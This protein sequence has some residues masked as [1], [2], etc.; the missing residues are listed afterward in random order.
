MQSSQRL[1]T[2]DE[3]SAPDPPVIEPP[4]ESSYVTRSGRV[5]K[6]VQHYGTWS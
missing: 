5:V 6:P 1:S 4:V 3:A 2:G